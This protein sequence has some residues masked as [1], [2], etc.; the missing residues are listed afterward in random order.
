M[1]A[2]PNALVAA[3]RRGVTDRFKHVLDSAFGNEETAD[4]SPF[5][6]K[7][8]HGATLTRDDTTILNDLAH[9]VRRVERG[10]IFRDGSQPRSVVVVLEG[11][12]SRYKQLENGRRQ[13]T[14]IFVAGDLCEPFGAVPPTMDHTLSALTNSV[15]AFVTPQAIRNAVSSNPRIEEALW[16]DLLLWEALGREH[17]V[18]LG[19]R[20]ATER[21]AFF[22]CEMHERL[23]MVGR[24]K[25]ESFELPLT[26]VD[27]AD[28]F[29]LSPVHVNRSLQDLRN[30]GLLSLRGRRATLH[31][32]PTLRDFAMFDPTCFEPARNPLA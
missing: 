28:L 17:M 4:N 2:L 29:G 32:L 27:L 23:R 7:L 24:V 9:T 31:D 26:Q 25:N 1:P 15:L 10:D 30:N 22:F 6:C 21:L 5:V 12:V 8:R 16:W 14:S 20:L 3:S 18:S 11:W 19:R 13:I